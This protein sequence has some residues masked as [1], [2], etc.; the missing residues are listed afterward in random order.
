MKR[1][2][3]I[4]RRKLG[5]VFYIEDTKTRKQ[6]SLGTKDRAEATALLNARNEAA[7]QRR[8]SSLQGRVER[9]VD[10]L[11]ADEEEGSEEVRDFALPTKT[12]FENERVL[13]ETLLKRLRELAQDSKWNHCAETFARQHDL[14]ELLPVLTAAQHGSQMRDSARGHCKRVFVGM[15]RPSHLLCLAISAEH[16]ADAQI[17]AL[18]TYGWKIE[19]IHA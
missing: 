19:K 5:G 1:R 13:L 12:F 16:I 9:L 6:E 10:L 8:L 4:Y 11:E 14:K 7:R 18:A 3:I 15:S 17:A 2:F